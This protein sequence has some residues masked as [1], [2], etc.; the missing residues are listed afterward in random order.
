MRIDQ[1]PVAATLK[2][3]DRILVL[4]DPATDPKLQ[5]FEVVTPAGIG[6]YTGTSIER[7][8]LGLTLDRTNQGTCFFD[9]DESRPYWWSG[10]AWV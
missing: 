7:V 10:S 9:S 4:T 8:A 3:G 5:T 6:F 1:Y 2:P